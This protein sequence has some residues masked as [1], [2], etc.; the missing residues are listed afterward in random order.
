MLE[1][2]NSSTFK[3]KHRS[4]DAE[5]G[6]IKSPDFKP[7]LKLNRWD[8]ECFLAVGFE[9][10]ETPIPEQAAD[11]LKWKG[12]KVEAH[13]YP[14]EPREVITGKNKSTQNE[15]GGVEF[16]IVL[17]EKPASNILTFPIESEGLRFAYQPPLHPDHPTWADRNGDGKADR[18]CPENVVGSYAIYHATKKNNE[19]MTGKAFHIYRPHL[20]DAL[21][22]EAWADLNISNGAL[23]ITLP[24]Q[25]L[26]EAVYPVT[27]DPTFGYTT[28]GSSWTEIAAG[29]L[30]TARLGS[31]WTMPAPGGT[32][33][34][35]KASIW[36]DGNPTDCKVFINQKDSGGAG[37][38]GQIATKENLACAV[39]GHWEQFN[40]AGEA[41]TAGVVYIL[42]IDGDKDDPA[43]GDY[44]IDYDY[45]GTLAV[46]SYY[47]YQ[48]YCSEESPW[49]CDPTTPAE[50][51]S[52]YC[53]YT[54]AV[55][56]WTGKISGV[57]DPA[58][59]MGV[60]VADVAKVKGVA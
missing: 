47:D 44:Y 40:L 12:S 20:V 15:L 45:N 25:F 18:F 1:Q 60:A 39:G 56:G 55:V 33:N 51:F 31:A 9:T 52:I 6:N 28:E 26:D 49:E 50:D 7:H 11:R 35:I 16:E 53:D 46:A 17:K 21:G 34:Y 41:L 58:K 19:Y 23:T 5:I 48:T 37:V 8:G 36:G 27:I 22:A 38:H 4:V 3:L 30:W 57:T 14:L 59:V 10:D 54:A 29:G 42:N 2:I 43:P 24:Q 13:F 32:A